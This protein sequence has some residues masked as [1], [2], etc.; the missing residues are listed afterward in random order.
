M[1]LLSV[2]HFNLTY[3]RFYLTDDLSRL[4]INTK[5]FNERLNKRVY[6]DYGHKHIEYRIENAG[7][8][9]CTR[10]HMFCV[11]ANLHGINSLRFWCCNYNFVFS[12]L[13][14]F[15]CAFAIDTYTLHIV[16]MLEICALINLL[17]VNV[18]VNR[19]NENKRKQQRFRMWVQWINVDVT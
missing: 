11:R 9:L 14:L 18:A 12:L 4:F 10:F 8:I 7:I 15:G 6:T 13:L 5:R 3:Q 1:H 19:L 2:P 17:P 16:K